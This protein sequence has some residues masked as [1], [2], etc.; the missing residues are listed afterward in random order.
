MIYRSAFMS[1]L[2]TDN[3]YKFLGR[4]PILSNLISHKQFL[5]KVKGIFVLYSNR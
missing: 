3:F 4:F 2:A 1:D 5:I